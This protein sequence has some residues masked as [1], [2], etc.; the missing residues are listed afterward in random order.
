MKVAPSFNTYRSMDAAC[1][2][3]QLVLL[4]CDGA[5]RYT[6]EAAEHMHANRWSE[7]G[8]A[9][10][11]ALECIGELRKCLNLSE[12]SEFVAQINQT[13]SFLATKL[14]IGNASRDI[15]QL[16]Q[17]ADALTNIR[18]AWSELFDRLRQEGKLPSGEFAPM[19]PATHGTTVAN[20]SA[21]TR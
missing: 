19:V 10:E 20:H 13:Y 1:S 4:L 2:T 14:S 6:R 21:I 17:V 12:N 9:I 16:H 11:S 15:S 5:I 18:A 7:K 3:P 8:T